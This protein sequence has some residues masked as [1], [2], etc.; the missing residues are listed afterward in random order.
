[1]ELRGEKA[2]D[3]GGSTVDEEKGG[4]SYH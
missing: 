4:G 1:M 2:G 3:G